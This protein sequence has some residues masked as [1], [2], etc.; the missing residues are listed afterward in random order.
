MTHRLNNYLRTYRKRAGLSQ[1]EVAFLLGG[2]DGTKVSRHERFVRRPKLET[3]LGYQAIYRV[4]AEDLF[5]GLHEKV[6]REILRRGRTL[7]R[8]LARA[9]PDQMTAGK[10]AFLKTLCDSAPR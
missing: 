2:R 5:A 7:L 6:E 1:D 8:Q 4:P 3:V 10:L 9:A